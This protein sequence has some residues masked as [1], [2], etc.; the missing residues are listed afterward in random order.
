MLKIVQIRN[1]IQDSEVKRFY[2]YIFLCQLS[3]DVQLTFKSYVQQNQP[4]L[5]KWKT[6]SITMFTCLI[7]KVQLGFWQ[8]FSQ[9]H[10]LGHDTLVVSC[11]RKWS[12]PFAVNNIAL[13]VTISPLDIEK[14]NFRY[15]IVYS[16]IILW[17]YDVEWISRW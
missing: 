3:M 10:E 6:K 11:K 9:K 16:I 8:K 13:D 15:L 2:N 4:F 7:K 12:H 1:T 14:V 17:I 5:F